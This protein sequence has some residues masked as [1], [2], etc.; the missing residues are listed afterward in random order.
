MSFGLPL[1]IIAQQSEQEFTLGK[2]YQQL[3]SFNIDQIQ[4]LSDLNNL[5]HV[6]IFYWYGCESCYQVESSLNSYIKSHPQLKVKRTPLVARVNW[7]EQAYLQPLMEQL[8]ELENIPSHL[9]IYQQ[10]LS[11]CQVF[12]QY[13]SSLQ[14][15][16]DK[17]D[18]QQ[19]PVIDLSLIWESEKIYKKRAEKFSISQVP[20]IIINEKYKVDANQAGTARRLVEIVDFLLS[21]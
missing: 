11:D 1:S 2:D 15:L 3:D 19:L 4:N 10:C 20:T 6:E 14:W 7:R 16:T 12:S 18:Q 5:Y 17:L 9:E 8:S 13:A 21:Q